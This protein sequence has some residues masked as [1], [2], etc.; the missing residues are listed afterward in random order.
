M[1]IAVL[2]QKGG[3]GKSHVALL[4]AS[5]LKA[6]GQDVAIDDR[7][8][9]GSISYWMRSAGNI[10]SLKENP[11]AKFQVIDT[12]GHLDLK[13]KSVASSVADLISEADRLV[14][15]TEMSDAAIHG[16]AP[17][18]VMIKENM[19][20]EAKALVVFNKV[21]QRTLIGSR[22]P[23][24]LAEI[25]GIPAANNALPLASAYEQAYS[26]GWSAVRGVDRERVVNLT[27]EIIA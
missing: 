3:V 14:L 26:L 23:E 24:A 15:V 5:A 19:S 10:L 18:A 20:A 21:R 9:Q 27:L 25:L 1:K 12:P 13:R 8:P 4:V 2:N 17:M 6:A 22:D 16:T 11:N 7:D